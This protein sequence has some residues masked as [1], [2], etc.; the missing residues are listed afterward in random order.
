MVSSDPLLRS[1]SQ[2]HSL[3]LRI[4]RNM[5]ETRDIFLIDTGCRI[6]EAIEELGKSKGFGIKVAKGFTFLDKDNLDRVPDS[7]LRRETAGFTAVC[8]FVNK[9]IGKEQVKILKKN[10]IKLV[11]C[12]SAGFDNV[13]VE[14]CRAAGIRGARVPAY[15]P[16]SIAEY[17]I[18]CVFGLAKNIRR[19][20]DLTKEANFSLQGLESLLLENKTVGVIGTGGIG[21]CFAEKISG[22]VGEVICF[23]KYPNRQWIKTLRNGRYVDDVDELFA[24]VNVISIHV[25]LLPETRHLINEENL[26]KMKDGVIIVN[27]SRGEIISTH[28]LVVAIRSGK[29]GGAALD[30]FEGEK[31]FIFKN[32]NPGYE[33]FPDLEELTAQ[34]NVILSGHVAF[35]TDESIREIASKTIENLEGFLGKG[36]LDDRAF[37]A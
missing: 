10:G 9:M 4:A 17:A 24:N 32:K 36:K 35:Y 18:T 16:S 23:D 11:L 8:L 21:R 1:L 14:A 37:L 20:C 6:N 29:V 5:S 12:C 13:P 2:S 7:A 27:T 30:V 34:G 31:E 25:P 19:N 26:R 33:N 15:S 3:Y 28:D 22:L